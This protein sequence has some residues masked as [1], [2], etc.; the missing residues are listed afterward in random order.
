MNQ[1]AGKELKYVLKTSAEKMIIF[2]MALILIIRCNYTE[3]IFKFTYGNISYN[4][5]PLRSQTTCWV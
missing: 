2:E 3:W 4:N 5:E 1:R